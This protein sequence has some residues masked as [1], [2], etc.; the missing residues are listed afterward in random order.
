MLAPF[1][2][3]LFLVFCI[4][5]FL[6]FE[7]AERRMCGRLH[8][9]TLANYNKPEWISRSRSRCSEIRRLLRQRVNRPI[10]VS[11][12]EECRLNQLLAEAVDLDY[13][14]K[15]APQL[16]TTIGRREVAERADARCLISQCLH[17][18]GTA[19]TA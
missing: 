11:G 2:K 1:L 5:R 9:T 14:R 6:R 18:T 19:T 7:S 12:C 8:H 13:I 3:L 4:Y 15:W 10:L 16:G 17:R